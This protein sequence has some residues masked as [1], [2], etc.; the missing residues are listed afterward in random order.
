[1]TGPT[2]YVPLN[3]SQHP[4]CQGDDELKKYDATNLPL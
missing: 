2:M 4:A 1:M 3:S